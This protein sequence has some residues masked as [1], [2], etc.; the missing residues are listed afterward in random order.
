[1]NVGQM[2]S[3]DYRAKQ[4]L[5]ILQAVE[6]EYTYTRKESTKDDDLLFRLLGDKPERPHAPVQ[7]DLDVRLV[8]VD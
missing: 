7:C 3:Q 8:V 2:S 6:A 4:L 5:C 1:M